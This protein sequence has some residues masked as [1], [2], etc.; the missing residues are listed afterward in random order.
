MWNSVSAGFA[1]GGDRKAGQESE[2]ADGIRAADVMGMGQI[3]AGGFE[4]LLDF[5]EVGGLADFAEADDIRR[6]FYQEPDDRFFSESGL[7]ELVAACCP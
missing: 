6:V 7:G 1:R 5:R 2:V 3:K 4:G